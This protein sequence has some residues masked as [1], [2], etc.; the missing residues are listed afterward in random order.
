MNE[1]YWQNITLQQAMERIENLETIVAK[2][3]IDSKKLIKEKLVTETEGPA[4]YYVNWRR[5]EEDIDIGC[6]K[7][8]YKLK[9]QLERIQDM[10]AGYYVYALEYIDIEEEEMS[11][12]LSRVEV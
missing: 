3:I 9:G 11:L 5:N 1:T 8:I 6:I 7:D 12:S 2:Q 10:Y 4:T